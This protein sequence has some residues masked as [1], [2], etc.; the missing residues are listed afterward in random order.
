MRLTTTVLICLF[1]LTAGVPVLNTGS[2]VYATPIQSEEAPQILNARLKGK[3]LFVTGQNFAPDAVILVNG[4]PQK[5]RNDSS[6][7]STLLIA[8]KAGKKIANNAV[9]SLQVQSAGVLSEKFPVFK[10]QIITFDNAGRTLQLTVGERFLLSLQKSGYEFSPEVLD[11]TVLRKVDDVEDVSGSQGVFEAVKAGSTK[12]TALGELPCHKSTPA[13]LAP[14]L[15]FELNIV[16]SEA[17][18]A[19]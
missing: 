7:P 16:V 11:P 15:F 4:K 3:K 12:L 5:T 9:V 1:L 6:S 19:N 13:C 2:T 18:P 17:E 14:T 10:G 8:G